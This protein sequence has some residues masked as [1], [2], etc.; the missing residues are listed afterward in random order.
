M[1]TH[2]ICHNLLFDAAISAL[3]AVMSVLDVAI[4][5]LGTALL[6][7]SSFPVIGVL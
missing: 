5:V 7:L 1:V 6:A 2:I 3:S 4:S